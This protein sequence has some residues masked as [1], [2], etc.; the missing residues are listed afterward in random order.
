MHQLRICSPGGAELVT[1]LGRAELGA[2]GVDREGG[3]APRAG[4]IAMHVMAWFRRILL[5]LRSMVTAVA[6]VAEEARSSDRLQGGPGRSG[7]RRSGRRAT[8]FARALAGDENANGPPDE[9]LDQS[10]H[11]LGQ[12]VGEMD[13][14]NCWASTWNGN[15]LFSSSRTKR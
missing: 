9:S 10:E 12:T 14:E 15:S 8:L 7:K 2:L 6:M 11:A 1:E 4:A 3:G 5:L 13:V